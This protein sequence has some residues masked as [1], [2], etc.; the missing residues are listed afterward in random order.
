MISWL[1]TKENEVPN[2]NF[3]RVADPNDPK[4]W[5]YT[6]DPNVRFDYCDIDSRCK[7]C[8]TVTQALGYKYDIFDEKAEAI[9]SVSPT[10]SPTL[11]KIFGGRQ[12][13][14]GEVPW[15]VNLLYPTTSFSAYTVRIGYQY[16]YSFCG[17]VIVSNRKVL[18][19]AHCFMEWDGSLKS[20]E[21]IKTIAGHSSISSAKQTMDLQKFLLHP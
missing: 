19:A 15:Q 12:V 1:Q 20:A 16:Y 7:K 6:T 4:P 10:V 9:S 13:K 5:C 3:C 8:G 11:N 17:G 18:S 14:I 21:K 2:H